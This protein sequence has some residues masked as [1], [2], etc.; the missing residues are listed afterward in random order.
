MSKIEKMTKYVSKYRKVEKK[1]N[2]DGL[3]KQIVL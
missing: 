3:Y 2:L 1:P